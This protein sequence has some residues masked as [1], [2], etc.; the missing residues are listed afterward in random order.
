MN[1][2]ILII[3]LILVGIP[4]LLIL[5]KYF[6]KTNTRQAAQ[7]E[8]EKYVKRLSALNKQYV[9]HQKQLISNLNLIN[10]FLKTGKD[11]HDP[12]AEEERR[13]QEDRYQRKLMTPQEAQEYEESKARSLLETANMVEVD[14]QAKDIRQDEFEVD[15]LEPC[16]VEQSSMKFYYKTDFGEYIYY[17]VTPAAIEKKYY[18][19][20]LYFTTSR[21]A[22]MPLVYPHKY[23]GAQMLSLYKHPA[24]AIWFLQNWKVIRDAMECKPDEPVKLNET[25]SDFDL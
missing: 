24:Q 25:I 23:E 15:R 9:P 7:N 11:P 5:P 20:V 3:V 1:I 10:Y 14:Q 8:F 2:T 21:P 18:N 4:L 6:V 13:I 22:S 17:C 12:Q 16:D 19:N